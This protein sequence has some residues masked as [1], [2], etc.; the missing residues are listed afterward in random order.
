M[1]TL[2]L[3]GWQGRRRLRN[4]L[5]RAVGFPESRVLH[6]TLKEVRQGYIGIIGMYMV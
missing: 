5:P 6:G 2:S 4:G 3:G 1:A